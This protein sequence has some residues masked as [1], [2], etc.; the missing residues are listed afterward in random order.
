MQCYR[1]YIPN[2]FEVDM[3]QYGHSDKPAATQ[4]HVQQVDSL[5]ALTTFI[6]YPALSSTC[7]ICSTVAHLWD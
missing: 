5:C 6:S 2:I 3:D 7:T 1:L 4:T